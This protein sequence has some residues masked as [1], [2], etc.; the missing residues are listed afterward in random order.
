MKGAKHSDSAYRFIN[1]LLDPDVQAAIAAFKKGSPTVTN[2]KVDPETAKLPGVFTTAE[3]WKKQTII[4][5]HKLRSEKLGEWRKWF[6]EN[7]MAK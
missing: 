4:I 3:Q 2:A 6:A 7:I 1:T 5:D